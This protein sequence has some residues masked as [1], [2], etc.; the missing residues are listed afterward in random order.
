MLK[1]RKDQ[2]AK[3]DRWPGGPDGLPHIRLFVSLQSD[4]FI[5]CPEDITKELEKEGGQLPSFE[6]EKKDSTFPH[7]QAVTP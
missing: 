2:H 4:A 5:T 7:E 6:K 3:S 1:S